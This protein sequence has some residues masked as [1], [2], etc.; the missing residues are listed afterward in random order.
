MSEK[1][2]ILV[3]ADHPFTPSGVGTQTKYFCEALLKTGKYKIVN[4]GGAIKH[5]NYQPMKTK[6]WDED[7]VIYP[8]DGYGSQDI[9]RS[10]LKNE[11]PDL[12]WF[13]TDPRFWGWLWAIDNEIRAQVP[14]V[15]HHVWDNKPYPHFN[16]KYYESNDFIVTI[17]KLTD[18]IVKTVAPDVPSQYLPHAV[19]SD[20]FCKLTEQEVTEAKEA[21]N[22][23]KDKFLFFW[24]NR[25]ARRK[26]SGTLI[27]WFKKFLDIVGHDKATLMMHTEPKDQNGQDLIAIIR[28]LGLEDGQVLLS[29]KKVDPKDLNVMINMMDCTINISDAEGFGL[30]TLESL[31][32]ETP[33]IVNMTGG[34]QEQVTDGKNWFGI[35]LE[36]A[37]K[38]VIGSQD[39]PYIYEDRLNEQEFVDALL[40]IYNMS[41]E[42][43]EELGRLGRQHVEKNYNFKTFNQSWVD[44]IEHVIEEHG[45][46]E[47]RKNYKPYKLVEIK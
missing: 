27:F 11:K 35:G 3:L 26:Q 43:R 5:P 44:V 37:S 22:L 23:P 13:M 36:P 21:S 10:I 31:S 45:S 6:E 7:W 1:K 41:K 33:I 47:T 38:A 15:Y 25:N 19:D 46:W 32:T 17:S 34:L 16:K 29:T 24:N 8:V 39:V 42:E 9:V 30:A 14:M 4:L 20:I 40:K 18:D 12:V 2:K 28:D